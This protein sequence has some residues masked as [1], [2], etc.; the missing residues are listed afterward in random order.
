MK[1]SVTGKEIKVHLSE[2]VLT[3]PRMELPM[4]LA[5]W[6]EQGRM[7]V[8][9]QLLKNPDKVDF[10]QQHLPVLVT[11][12]S[13]SA[14]PFNCGNKGVGS[15]PKADS[16]EKYIGLYK[17]TIEA[18]KGSPWRDSLATRIAAVKTF[19]E[20]RPAIDLRCLTSIEI[21]QKQTFRNLRQSPL[22]SLLFTG[23][24][25]EYKSFQLNCVAEIID[26]DDPRFEFIKLSRRLFE[27][28][29]FHIAQ[30]VFQYGYVF[31]IS[32]VIDKTPHRIA[33]QPMKQKMQHAIA[34]DDEALSILHAMPAWSRGHVKA[35]IE[36]YGAERGYSKVT[37][38]L[39]IEAQKVL[40][41]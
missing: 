3:M 37:A 5:S 7:E 21:F 9:R 24:S 38:D 18:T 14:F 34:W 30:P 2:E 25:P 32:E 35:Q 36:Q 23:A 27:F 20:D 29:G 4:H 41:H 28:D 31:W 19:Y 26:R 22:A 13:Q 16:L 39:L 1:V 10:F 17:E 11:Q 8:Y 6:L 40:R 15:L 12:S 33:A